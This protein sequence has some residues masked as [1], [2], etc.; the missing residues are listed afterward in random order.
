M[1]STALRR[2]QKQACAGSSGQ[3]RDC[4]SSGTTR[5]QAC[6]N[7]SPECEKHLSGGFS[8]ML[9]NELV[10]ALARDYAELNQGTAYRCHCATTIG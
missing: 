8:S 7:A 2:M 5:T 4:D 10:F 1:E 6:N 3:V 9:V